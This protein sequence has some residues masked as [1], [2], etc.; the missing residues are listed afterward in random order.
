M[1][2]ESEI[3]DW[4]VD[5]RAAACE[6]PGVGSGKGVGF[7]VDGELG[8]DRFGV[9]EADDDPAPLSEGSGGGG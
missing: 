3:F 6:V 9:V 5:G 4:I 2:G 7:D 1:V 8:P